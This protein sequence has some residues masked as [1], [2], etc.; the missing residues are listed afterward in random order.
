MRGLSPCMHS[1]RRAV[2]KRRAVR[3]SSCSAGACP[4]AH[5]AQRRV[6]AELEIPCTGSARSLRVGSVAVGP[7]RESGVRRENPRVADGAS[8]D[9]YAVTSR[10]IKSVSDVLRCDDVAVEH[11]GH[12]DGFFTRE[13]HE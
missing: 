7:F 9:H 13:I 10:R 11:Y 8:A 5:S 3:E 1:A 2:V 6:P 4:A 12:G